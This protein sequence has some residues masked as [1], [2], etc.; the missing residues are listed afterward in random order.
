MS[1]QIS[2]LYQNDSVSTVI[3]TISKITKLMNDKYI[4]KTY[5]NGKYS[6]VKIAEF[7]S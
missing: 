6:E 3:A 1:N 4:V 7:K 5:I 2:T